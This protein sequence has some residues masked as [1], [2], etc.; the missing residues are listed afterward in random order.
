VEFDRRDI[1]WLKARTLDGRDLETIAA[2]KS[3][4]RFRH[5]IATRQMI[6]QLVEKHHYHANDPLANHFRYLLENKGKEKGALQIVRI[7][8]EYM[9]GLDGNLVLNNTNRQVHQMDDA[10][11][12]ESASYRWAPE[13]AN[14]RSQS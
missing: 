5:G 3:W 1:R 10:T 4:L 13:L 8:D 7:Y 6:N 2:P 11:F 14:H 9:N 12:P